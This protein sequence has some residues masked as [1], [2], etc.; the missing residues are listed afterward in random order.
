M[1]TKE[2]SLIDS[3]C[4]SV[5]SRLCLPWGPVAQGF[6]GDMI[7]WARVFI[8]CTLLASQGSLGETAGDACSAW[9]RCKALAPDPIVSAPLR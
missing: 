7:V 8:D 3:L 6:R 4:V 5:A 9:S 2:H 1:K